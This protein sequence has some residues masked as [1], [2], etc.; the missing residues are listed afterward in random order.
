MLDASTA[1]TRR[2]PAWTAKNESMPEPAPTSSTTWHQHR[3]RRCNY[4]CHRCHNFRVLLYLPTY[5]KTPWVGLGLSKEN[6]QI[7]SQV[8]WPT[9][10]IKTLMQWHPVYY[11]APNRPVLVIPSRYCTSC[12]GC[13]SSSG[14]CTSW[15]FWHTKFGARPLRSTYTAKSQDAL[16]AELYVQLP[17][18][19]WTNRSWE[20]T[21]PSVLSGLQHRLSGT[22]CHKQFSSVILWLFSNLDLKLFCSV[23]L[24][25]N[26][27]PTCRQ[28]LWSYDRMAL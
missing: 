5:P 13:Q 7:F 17:F 26:T 27:D 22:R 23:R 24:L 15:Q 25:L 28:R 20:Q 6:Q 8:A 19:C 11:G 3:A 4:Y 1:Y 18:C 10:S 2:A 21:S 16:A 9:N 14:S 12:I